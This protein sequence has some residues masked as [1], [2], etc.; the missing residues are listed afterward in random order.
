MYANVDVAVRSAAQ[1]YLAKGVWGHAP[2]GKFDNFSTPEVLSEAISEVF[3][4]AA[5]CW[6][7]SV[8]QVV[9]RGL[10]F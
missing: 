5:S 7:I 1:I 2:P 3:I 8:H 6:Q 9:T 10:K 4:Y